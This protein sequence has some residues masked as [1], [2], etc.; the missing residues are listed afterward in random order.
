MIFVL[1]KVDNVEG[2]GENADGQHF[3]QFPQCFQ[4]FDSELLKVGIVL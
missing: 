3:L 1:E 4:A 2:K